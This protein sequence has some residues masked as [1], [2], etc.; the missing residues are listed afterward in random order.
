MVFWHLEQIG[1][2]KKLEWVP[3]ELTSN[4]K[5]SHFEVLSYLI[6]HNNN[7]PFLDQIGCAA[8][9]GFYT[10]TSNDQL[11]GWTKKKCQSTSQTQTLQKKV[12]VTVWWSAAHLIHYSFLNPSETITCEEY[13]Q[14]IDE[15]HQKL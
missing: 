5:K 7:K 6:L 15:M 14:Q 9:S 2:V 4:L 3:H 8:K 11:S 1:K 10:T 13:A 12:M